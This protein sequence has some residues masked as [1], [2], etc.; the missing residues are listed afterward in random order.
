M[1]PCNQ[2]FLVPWRRD[3]IVDGEYWAWMLWHR[4]TWNRYQYW[5]SVSPSPADRNL[6]G[7]SCISNS[8]LP[9]LWDSIKGYGDKKKIMDLILGKSVFHTMLS[10]KFHREE[11]RFDWMKTENSRWHLVIFHTFLQNFEN[12]KIQYFLSY[13]SD[14]PETW[15]DTLSRCG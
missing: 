5:H 3:S 11:A 6:M 7:V 10:R 1:G 12:F 15:S 8:L 13:G 9:N 2:M 4:L 14:W